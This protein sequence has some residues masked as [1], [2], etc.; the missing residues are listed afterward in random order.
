[1]KKLPNLL[2][3]LALVVG[4]VSSAQSQALHLEELQK[5]AALPAGLPF[6]RMTA[7]LFPPSWAYRGQ[8]GQTDETYWT[9]GEVE[10]TQTDE[11]GDQALADF[12]VSL[13]PMPGGG[14][15]VLYKTTHASGFEPLHRE[16]RRQKLAATPVT[17]VECEGIRYDGGTY[18]ITFYSHKKSGYP[19]IVVLHPKAA[20]P[21]V[22]TPE[23]PAP[24]TKIANN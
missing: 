2:L 21:G 13:R 4:A 11:Y 1:M 14:V 6:K 23:I 9:A 12:W 10:A 3:V 18:T 19:F 7:A 24:D 22:D 17:C 15:D 16:L 5:L 20:V 8:V